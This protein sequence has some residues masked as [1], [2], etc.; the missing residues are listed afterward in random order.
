MSDRIV[1]IVSQVFGVPECDVDDDSSPDSIPSWDSL[2]H[3]HLVLALEAE[4]GVT[5]TPDEAM[6]LLS[7]HLIR[8]ILADKNVSLFVE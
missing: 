5:L 8:R 7:V 2:T 3:I 1:K 6:D 4:F